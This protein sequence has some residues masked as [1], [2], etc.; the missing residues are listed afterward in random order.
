[1][2]KGIRKTLILLAT[3]AVL[4]LMVWLYFRPYA[5]DYIV[6]G[7]RVSHPNNVSELTLVDG[8]VPISVSGALRRKWVKG[9]QPFAIEFSGT[10]SIGGMVFD[11]Y[12]ISFNEEGVGHFMYGQN[13][14]EP[15]GAAAL[16]AKNRFSEG[17]VS[18]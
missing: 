18:F 10:L 8:A 2:K 9:S 14:I 4:G 6:N 16:F 17:Y 12:S 7:M 11:D 5:V 13:S 1:M 15:Y 3:G